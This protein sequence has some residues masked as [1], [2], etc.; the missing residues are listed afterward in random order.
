MLYL[1]SINIVKNESHLQMA[2]WLTSGV[3]PPCNTYPGTHASV[4]D[5]FLEST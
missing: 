1:L 5:L 4:E 2:E 3:G